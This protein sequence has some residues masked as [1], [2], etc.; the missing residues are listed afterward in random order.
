EGH[1]RAPDEP[2]HAHDRDQDDRRHP[3]MRRLLGAGGG[4]AVALLALTACHPAPS[5]FTLLCQGPSP[6]ARVGSLS[7]APDP[8]HSRPVGFDGALHVV[9]TIAD[10]R[11]ATTMAV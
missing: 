7:W 10:P 1:R 9:R 2:R 5:G 6:A 4:A 11:L 3:L 8:D